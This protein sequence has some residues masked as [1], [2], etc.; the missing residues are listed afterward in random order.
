[1][2]PDKFRP[3]RKAL[4]KKI[5]EL[6]IERDMT[7]TDL[8]YFSGL[9]QESISLWERGLA[10]PHLFNYIILCQALKCSLEEMVKDIEF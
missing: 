5:A 9:S 3:Q 4:G 1:M 2:T 7:Q 10:T 8:A 6:R